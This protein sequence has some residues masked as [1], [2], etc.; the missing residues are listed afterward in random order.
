MKK[1]MI[2]PHLFVGPQQGGCRG[3]IEFNNISI[4]NKNIAPFEREF[5]RTYI[6]K[7]IHIAYKQRIIILAYY[8]RF[9][10]IKYYIFAC[11][12]FI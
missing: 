4:N 1:F 7:S 8:I 12:S 11:F 2:K 9:G 5:K 3:I 6:I 10:Q